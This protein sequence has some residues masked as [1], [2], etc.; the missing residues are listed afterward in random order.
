MK[1]FG[2]DLTT[3]LQFILTA[4]GAGMLYMMRELISQLRARDLEDHKHQLTRENELQKKLLDAVQFERQAKF[5]WAHQEQAE[6]IKQVHAKLSVAHRKVGLMT[7]P[8]QFGAVDREEQRKAAADAYDALDEYFTAHQLLL[9]AKRSEQVETLIK[10]MR[11]SFN[12]FVFAQNMQ[13]NSENLKM[14][15]GAWTRIEEEAKPVLMALRQDFR[16]ALTIDD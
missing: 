10:M 8:A 12:E 7:S 16:G 1:G 2:M 13:P 6:A 5:S 15:I 4:V 9:S 3:V 14:A 11:T